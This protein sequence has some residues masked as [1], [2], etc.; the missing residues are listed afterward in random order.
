MRFQTPKLGKDTILSLKL[1]SSNK[2][3]IPKFKQVV[4][5]VNFGLMFV[6]QKSKTYLSKQILNTHQ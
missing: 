6:V 1:Q 3:K 4:T 2:L 5:F